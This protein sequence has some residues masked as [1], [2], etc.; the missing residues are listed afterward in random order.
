MN[1]APQ[2]TL[3]V[4]S[5]KTGITPAANAFTFAPPAGAI[6]LTADALAGLDELPQSA[7][8]GAQP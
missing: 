3:R 5:W 1:S 8:T 7:P 4:K 2:Y 6:R